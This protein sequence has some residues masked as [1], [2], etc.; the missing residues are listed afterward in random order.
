[1]S[2]NQEVQNNRW[3]RGGYKY[4]QNAV[5]EGDVMQLTQK[6]HQSRFKMVISPERV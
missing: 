6:T 3:G 4:I 2:Y 1:M 5:T